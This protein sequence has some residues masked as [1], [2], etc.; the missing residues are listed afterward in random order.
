M[1]ATIVDMPKV[2]QMLDSGWYMYV[3]KN[4]MGTYTAFARHKD[5]CRIESVRAKMI[6][7][8]IQAGWSEVEAVDLASSD[9]RS[10]G[11]IV[12]DDFTPEQAMTRLAYKVF[13]ETL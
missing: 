10:G 11:A 9:V 7:D 3:F 4:N 6:A 5:M 8:Y 2:C 12:T 13:G 1:S